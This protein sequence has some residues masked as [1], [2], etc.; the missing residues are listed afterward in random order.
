MN[1]IGVLSLFFVISW[2]A[3]GYAAYSILAGV[4]IENRTFKVFIINL[5]LG[6]IALVAVLN[7]AIKDDA[8]PDL[9]R[10]RLL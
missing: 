9:Q 6:M 3:C 7:V 1:L 10:R 2:L 8:Y 5:M 4:K